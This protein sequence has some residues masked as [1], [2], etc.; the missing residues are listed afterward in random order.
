MTISWKNP[1]RPNTSRMVTLCDASFLSDN[2]MG[3]FP[4][5]RSR[6]WESMYAQP[7]FPGMVSID[8]S[9]AA[10]YPFWHSWPLGLWP[11]GTQPMA[12]EH[13]VN[14][15]RYGCTPR[16][17]L[18]FPM[19]EAY[20][21]GYVP[22]T[23]KRTDRLWLMGQKKAGIH[24]GLPPLN[25]FA[26]RTAA[27]R[28]VMLDAMTRF[29]TD[30]G[31]RIVSLDLGSLASQQWGKTP[32]MYWAEHMLA[33]GIEVCIEAQPFLHP[34][35]F[36]WLDGR[37]GAVALYPQWD[38][39]KPG[40]G[41]YLR[42]EN[43]PFAIKA[44]HLFLQGSDPMVSVTKL[45]EEFAARTDVGGGHAV[46]NFDAPGVPREWWLGPAGPATPAAA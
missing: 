7:I 19:M 34:G 21:A 4:Q 15:A 14:K 41:L 33:R 46:V 45:A 11:E 10:G 42:P 18:D 9:I 23:R 22:A 17:V 8:D 25:A 2:P 36:P 37:F 35:M 26:N 32:A 12:V 44:W 27:Q 16:S 20:L 38:K 3:L 29:V 39:D 31:Y 5:I 43:T 30:C 6:G 13:P 40:N 24:V 28:T 1:L